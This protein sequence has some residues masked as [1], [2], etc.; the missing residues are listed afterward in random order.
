MK[1]KKLNK[2]QQSKFDT[3]QYFIT[4][5]SAGYGYLP[6]LADNEVTNITEISA[7]YLNASGLWIA[8]HKYGRPEKSR[9]HVEPQDL[10]AIYRA[11]KKSD[12]DTWNAF[13][14]IYK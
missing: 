7:I 9:E 2:G 8:G 11:L 4:W 12:L 6:C 14:T 5:F 1:A 10:T 3:I 13:E